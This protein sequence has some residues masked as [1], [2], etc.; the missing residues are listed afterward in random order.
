EIV[1]HHDAID[2]GRL[3]GH[4]AFPEQVRLL[5]ETG[6]QHRNFA[7]DERTIPCAGNLALDGHQAALSILHRAAIHLVV[8]RVA[9]TGVLVRI[10]E[11]AHVVEL[12]CLHELAKLF[13]IVLSFAWESDDEAGANGY[14]WNRAANALQQSQEN[15]AR[16]AALHALQHA[17]AA[18]ARQRR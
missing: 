8:E 15:I 9:A 5:G 12:G 3:R 17:G 6:D 18:A 11:D 1:D 14:A 16:R 2:I 4:A 10:R 7:I 13:E